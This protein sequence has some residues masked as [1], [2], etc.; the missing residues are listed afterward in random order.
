MSQSK[1][2]EKC[3]VEH[4]KSECHKISH[5]NKVSLINVNTMSET[6]YKLV[7]L[8]SYVGTEVLFNICEHHHVYYF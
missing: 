5:T 8:R 7:H 6:D 1:C 2:L 3:S 4:S